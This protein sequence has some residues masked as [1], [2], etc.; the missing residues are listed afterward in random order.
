MR[1]DKFDLNLLLAFEV[2]IEERNVTR[3]ARRLNLTQSAMS[4]ALRRLREAFSDEIL[5]Q[6]GKKMFPTAVA[7]ALAPEISS[8]IAGL[9]TLLTQEL[10]FTPAASE[11]LFRIVASD[12]ISIVLIGPLLE[13]LQEEAPHI[14][15]EITLPGSNSLEEL[16]DGRTDL[17]IAP[18]RFLVSNHPRDFLLEERHVV[19][20]WSK[21]PLLEKPL[22][23]EV[24][25]SLGHVV[26][27]LTKQ[28]TFAE[29]YL[30]ENSDKRRVEVTCA[31]FNEVAWMLPGTSRVALMHER[32]AKLAA[33]YLPLTIREPPVRLPVMRE[34]LLHHRAKT[35]DPGLSWLRSHLLR[36]AKT[37]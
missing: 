30:R 19:V 31:A 5:V 24:Y 25:E 27:S 15:I 14:R 7:L 1:L 8:I 10:K 23:K 11:R 4:G 32:L 17:I 2:L 16:E 33:Q 3:A 34:M 22:T 21:N 13:R 9:R 18:E 35:E 6:Q 37:I 12:Y 36:A 29:N 28:G 20:G 26:V